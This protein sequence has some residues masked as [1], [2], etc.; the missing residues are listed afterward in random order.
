MKERVLLLLAVDE[1]QL[2]DGLPLSITEEPD[3]SVLCLCLASAVG[4]WEAD[5]AFQVVSW[6]GSWLR[7][8]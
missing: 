7:V 3:H 2:G 4:G 8:L 5:I 6:D 1:F